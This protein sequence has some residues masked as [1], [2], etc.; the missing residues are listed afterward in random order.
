MR[1]TGVLAA[2]LLVSLLNFD[3]CLFAQD[4]GEPNYDAAHAHGSKMPPGSKCPVTGLTI[5]VSAPSPNS[6]ALVT[7][8]NAAVDSM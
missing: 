7:Q 1:A 6:P 8:G 3:P 5:P 2:L 4:S